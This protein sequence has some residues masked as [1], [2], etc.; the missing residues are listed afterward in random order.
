[1]KI[2]CDDFPVLDE[3]STARTRLNWGLPPVDVVFVDFVSYHLTD[4]DKDF[5]AFHLETKPL[6]L[7][8]AF[9]RL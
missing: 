3:R 2:L 6:F 5:V 1:M 9:D 8:R 4:L 7:L